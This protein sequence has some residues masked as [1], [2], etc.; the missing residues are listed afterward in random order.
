M[1]KA[2]YSPQQPGNLSSTL[3]HCFYLNATALVPSAFLLLMAN[4]ATAN[5]SELGADSSSDVNQQSV[6][7]EPPEQI[8][9]RAVQIARSGNYE[10]AIET[11]THLL[12]SNAD[13]AYALHDLLIILGWNEQDQE[14]L[15]L[16]DR[17]NPETAPVDVLETLAKAS[18]NVG[19]FEQSVRWYELAISRSPARL[20]S[21]LGLA[22]VHADMGH[23]EDAMRTLNAVA[24]DKQHRPRWLMAKAYVHS[25]DADYGKAI[26]AYDNVL[27][28][29]PNHRSALRGKILAMQRLLLPEQALEI[30]SA[31]PGILT[32]DELAQLRTD[33]A[34]VQIRW[35]NQTATGKSIA[36]Y[37]LQNTIDE[38]SDISR[39]FVDN[40]AA[41]RRT[42]FDRIV[43]LRSEWRMT[44]VVTEYEQLATSTDN[45]PAY[46]LRAAAGAYLYLEQP[47]KAREL[48]IRAL[49]QEPESFELNHDLFYVYVDLEQH[50]RAMSLAESMRESEPIWRQVPGSPVFKRNPQR[51]QAEIT[52]GVSLALADQLPQSQVRFETLLSRAPH[53]TDLRQ[54]L[55]TVYRWRG[56]TDRALF[57][58]EQVLSVE[59]ELTTARIGHAHA[60]LDRRKYELADRE[61][62]ALVSDRPAQRDV[63]RLRQRWEQHNKHQFHVESA[64]GDS[65]GV[66]FGSRQYSFD[67]YFFTRPLAYRYRPFVHTS[68]AF[69]EFPEGDARRRRIGAGI[70]YRGTDWS[71]D[72]E[73][74]VAR[75]GG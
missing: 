45:I 16:A 31:H 55:A 6:I 17:L 30:A 1:R 32:E 35:A 33:W 29:D 49:K 60:L 20:E 58:Y 2:N 23:Q 56:W 25:S 14:V 18:R 71:G 9:E 19:D 69:A 7:V 68:D 34:A 64:F 67:G 65:S 75:S 40:D 41:Q 26:L 72:L 57:E 36:D 46:V 22:M 3:M 11:L 52:A 13:D 48:L 44:E 50:R 10:S 28:D 5:P 51:M 43:A 4:F 61:I 63:M 24:I 73:L 21:H 8:R 12:E 15:N 66:Q 70:E 74:N 59:P 27:S 53:N 37:P 38:L 54:E 62:S 47:E 39:Q 42:R